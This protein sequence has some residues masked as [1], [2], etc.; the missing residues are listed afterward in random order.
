MLNDD[1]YTQRR[2][3]HRT[4]QQRQAEQS[5]R[6]KVLGRIA[7]DRHQHSNVLMVFVEINRLF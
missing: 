2:R 7:D 5:E 4:R 3:E 6:L 1:R